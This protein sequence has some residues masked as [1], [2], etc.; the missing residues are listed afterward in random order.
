VHFYPQSRSSSSKLI[1]GGGGTSNSESI[2]CIKLHGKSKKKKNLST[3]QQQYS[4]DWTD[5]RALTVEG[6]SV[7]MISLEILGNGGP[8][9]VLHHII[10]NYKSQNV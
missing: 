5:N 7:S 4:K 10:K 2:F 8:I 3:H 1:G 9:I 6:S